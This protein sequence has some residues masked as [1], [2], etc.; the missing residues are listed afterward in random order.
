MNCKQF[1]FFYSL[2]KFSML[3]VE[4]VRIVTI[5]A[6]KIHNHIPI[7]NYLPPCKKKI[8]INIDFNM[9]FKFLAIVQWIQILIIKVAG[10]KICDD[11]VKLGNISFHTI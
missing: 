8:S 1:F 6:I 2:S 9:K 10:I 4:I 3:A 7:Y 5:V 11:W